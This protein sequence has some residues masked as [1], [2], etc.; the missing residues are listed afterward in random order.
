MAGSQEWFQ[1]QFVTASIRLIFH[2]AL[3]SRHTIPQLQH[4]P[5]SISLKC[6]E[7]NILI[8]FILHLIKSSDKPFLKIFS[9]LI[10]YSSKIVK[11]SKIQLFHLSKQPFLAANAIQTT[12]FP[13][14]QKFEGV[15][16][17]NF[18]IYS[19]GLWKWNLDAPSAFITV[20][21]I[22][23]CPAVRVPIITQRGISPTVQSLTNPTSFAILAR[24]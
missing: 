18:E 1:R 14:I 12:I 17:S 5:D 3:Q 16:I 2:N 21:K 15:Q 19:L 8:I 20:S 4:C 13:V 23:N 7:I 22:P 6:Y 9:H 24:R 11:P 10:Y